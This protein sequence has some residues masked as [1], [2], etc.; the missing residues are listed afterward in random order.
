MNVYAKEKRR[1]NEERIPA[2]RE[3]G[4]A[5]TSAGEAEYRLIGKGGASPIHGAMNARANIS[6]KPSMRPLMKGRPILIATTAANKRVRRRHESPGE[7]IKE[8]VSS[9]VGAGGNGGGSTLT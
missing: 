2:H 1:A 6:P 3:I 4:S 5:G 9:P 7:K 8:S